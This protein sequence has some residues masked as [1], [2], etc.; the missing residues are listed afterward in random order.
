M[1]SSHYTAA[2]TLWADTGASLTR[3]GS[4]FYFEFLEQRDDRYT[5]YTP[6]AKYINH[7]YIREKVLRPLSTH[8][9]K[10]IIICRVSECFYFMLYFDARVVTPAFLSSVTMLVSVQLWVWSD[11]SCSFVYT[12]L[13]TEFY[14]F[15]PRCSTN[16][17]CF[18][19]YNL[20]WIDISVHRWC[21]QVHW[22][23]MQN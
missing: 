14:T 17:T 15:S 12:S 22:I 4:I 9:S 21:L 20:T 11:S 18:I 7:V 23:V 3:S 16:E 13:H 2:I 1:I 19:K 8:V 6:R 10:Y 5:F